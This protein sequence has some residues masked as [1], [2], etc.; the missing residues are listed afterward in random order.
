MTRNLTP[1]RLK[2]AL[3]LRLIELI[4]DGED[5]VT[6]DGEVIVVKAK[7]STLTAAINFLKEFP[8]E[9]EMPTGDELKANLKRYT[10]IMASA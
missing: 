6:K 3:L 2:E 4:E 9:G 8:P 10:G 1:A 7:A 5:H